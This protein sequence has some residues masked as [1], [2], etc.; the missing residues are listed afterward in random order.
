MDGHG[1]AIGPKGRGVQA[2]EPYARHLET[3]QGGQ[4]ISGPARGYGA[5]RV[6]VRPACSRQSGSDLS[7]G[8]PRKR[9]RH[10]ALLEILSQTPARYSYQGLFLLFALRQRGGTRTAGKPPGPQPDL[11]THRSPEATSGH[12]AWL[13]HFRPVAELQLLVAHALR[14]ALRPSRRR[15]AAC[16]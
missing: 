13:Q 5:R 4:A 1:P 11:D 7:A 8:W 2:N 16:N 3:Q 9:P 6:S 14:R 10:G 12:L 15:Q